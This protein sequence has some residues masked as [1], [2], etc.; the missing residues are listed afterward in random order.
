MKLTDVKVRDAKP[1]AK[2]YKLP[3]GRALYALVNPTGSK[4]WRGSYRFD[5]K[6]KTLAMGGYPDVSLE[7]ARRRWNEARK[8]KAQGIDPAAQ[9]KAD[10]HA[11]DDT[12]RAVGEELIAK[13]K[14]EEL[15]AKLKRE[16]RAHVTLTKMRWLLGFAFAAFGD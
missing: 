3:D 15:I 8:L 14:R 16:G 9:R 12:F 13:L 5:G 11:K 6:Q 7:E 2:P 4:L 10:K 1:R